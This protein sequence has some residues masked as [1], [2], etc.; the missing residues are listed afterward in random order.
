MDFAHVAQVGAQKVKDGSVACVA[1]THNEMPILPDF[2]EHYRSLGS[3]S[4]FIVDDCS[5]DGSREFLMSQPDV[6][7]FE[8]KPH[9]TFA[10]HKREW[11]AELLDAFAEGQW[12]LAPDID[13]H[14]VYRN[15]ETRPLSALLD[16]LDAEGASA[17]HCIMLDM[18]ADLP[19]ADHEYKGNG[20][21]QAF[22]LTD[23]PDAYLM[24]PAPRRYRAK[25]PT[26]RML[27]HGGMRDRVFYR[28]ERKPSGLTAA[29]LAHFAGIDGPLRPGPVRSLGAAFARRM[30]RSFMPKEPFICTKLTVIRWQKGQQFSGGAH[31]VQQELRIS[32][33]SAA[34]L[35]FKFARGVSAIEYTAA[36]GQHAGGSVHYR[37]MLER[38]EVLRR[39]PVYS[40]TVRYTD[41]S[42]LGW[43]LHPCD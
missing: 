28:P 2:L 34:L 43:I 37:H 41:S 31:S 12:C 26:P 20:L 3:V 38:Q 1:L 6:T 10:Q 35:H 39:S 40:G 16:D 24:L 23:G 13:E 4:F 30:A 29:A 9:S 11:R 27:C 19:L 18:Y 7:V 21:R 8:P 15:C 17:L 42:S 36:R 32:D 22:P 25:Y 5:D 14:L 33:H